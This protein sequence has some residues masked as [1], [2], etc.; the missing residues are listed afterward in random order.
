MVMKEF[1]QQLVT[2]SGSRCSSM[3]AVIVAFDFADH[4]VVYSR[5]P[6]CR[7]YVTN[8]IFRLDR[9]P[10]ELDNF[11]QQ[12]ALMSH[13]IE[14]IVL[15]II[16]MPPKVVT[17]LSVELYSFPEP[18]IISFC[19]SRHILHYA[20]IR[21]SLHQLLFIGQLVH[22]RLLSVWQVDFLT[23]LANV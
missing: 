8:N 16:I 23:C 19:H 3:Q 2:M 10:P 14:W 7:D 1:S 4:R 21:T 18:S 11:P 9:K 17:S 6:I 5:C 15:V 13:C 12:I 20:I 22:L